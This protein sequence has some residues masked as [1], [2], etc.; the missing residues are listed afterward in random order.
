MLSLYDLLGDGHRAADVL[1][2]ARGRE[3]QGLPR[4]S[5]A[6]AHTL[7]AS[8]DFEARPGQ[9]WVPG[10]EFITDIE[11]GRGAGKT[12]TGGET[13]NDCALSPDLWGGYACVVGPDPTE[14]L[15]DPL[16][17]KAGIFAAA[18]RRDRAGLG[19]GIRSRNLNQRI[20][21]FEAPRGGGGGGLTVHWAASSDPKSVHGMNVGFAWL[22]EFGVWYHRKQ[23]EQGNNAWQAL[24]P[25]I[26][27]GLS[28]V[29]ITQTPSRSPEVRRLQMDAE[30][31]ECPGCRTAYI[32]RSGRW[33]GEAGAEP[34]RLPRSPQLKLH[35]LLNTRTTVPTRECP[36][37]GGQVVASVRCVFGD[38]TDNPTLSARAR[39][40]AASEV[41]AGTAAGRMRFAPRGEVDSG[42]GGTLVHYED[43][44]QLECVADEPARFGPVRDRWTAALAQIGA[45]EVVVDV[46]P[47]VTTTDGSDETGVVVGTSR[48]VAVLDPTG[49]PTGDTVAGAV[50]LEDAS[51][52][53]QEVERGAP[54]SVWA[55]RAYRKAV[56]W[57]ARRILVETNQGGDE[58]LSAV[59]DLVRAGISE[60]TATAWLMEEMP[61]VADPARL[62]AVARRL[63]QSARRV[64]VESI[65]RVSDKPTRLEWYGR[66]AAIGRVDGDDASRPWGRQAVLCC[67]WLGGA[68]HWQPVLAQITGYEPPR[69]GGKRERPRKDRGDAAVSAAQVVLGIVEAS[70]HE[71]RDPRADAWMANLPAR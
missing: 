24:R 22:E 50:L 44:L 14:V 70:A 11:Q 67:P 5:R 17:G 20:L 1:A 61:E 13:I 47:A 27:L 12:R 10:P 54:S 32:V 71:V 63:V 19:P 38:T 30:R 3:V 52:R 28:K 25:A 40:D 39:A 55:P 68:Q 49:A 60:A 37:C 48:Q 56:L 65:R 58:V 66:T 35:P 45:E 59:Q 2:W 16:F 4:L 9:K 46:D 43:V 51:V 7:L 34:W 26:R 31:P 6:E 29:M 33:R 36:V 18:E 57:G 69:E 23:D 64:T 21:Q 41:A 53:P 62:A 15:R 8:W 42:S